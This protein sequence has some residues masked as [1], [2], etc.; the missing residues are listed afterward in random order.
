MFFLIVV[1]CNIEF[2][3]DTAAELENATFAGDVFNILFKK[4]VFQPSDVMVMQFLLQETE[5]EELD[6]KCVEYAKKHNAMYY[7]ETLPG[8]IFKQC[9]AYL[10][11][12]ARYEGNDSSD[13][14]K[15]NA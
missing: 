12:H 3:K 1:S 7:Y 8:I 11:I 4:E 2:D 13:I 10:V 14:E 15:K 9:I 5:C 6:K